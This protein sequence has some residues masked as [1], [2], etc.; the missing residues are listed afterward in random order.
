MS[1]ACP[2]DDFQLLLPREK[3][4][5][6]FLEPGVSGCLDIPRPL[7]NEMVSNDSEVR[8]INIV[9]KLDEAPVDA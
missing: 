3:E 8:T 4:H 2:V 1:E 5:G 6:P 7:E 9:R